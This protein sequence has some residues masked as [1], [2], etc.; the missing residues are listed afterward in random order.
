M[1]INITTAINI[2]LLNLYKLNFVISVT[3]TA[4]IILSLFVFSKDYYDNI[5]QCVT[6][7]NITTVIVN[8]FVCVQ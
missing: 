7:Y 5:A 3:I 6:M 2:I 4:V 1:S 8:I